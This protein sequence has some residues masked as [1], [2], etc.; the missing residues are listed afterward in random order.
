MG[1]VMA[2]LAA[3]LVVVAVVWLLSLKKSASLDRDEAVRSQAAAAE[4]ARRAEE[5]AKLYREGE[6]LHC[7]G[8]GAEFPGPLSDEGCPKCHIASLVVT[9]AQFRADQQQRQGLT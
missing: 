7:L 6:S 5:E 8:C 1:F 3:V 4:A 9:E 2:G